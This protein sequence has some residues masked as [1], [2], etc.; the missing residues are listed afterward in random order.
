M[1]SLSRVLIA[2]VL[3]GL[4]VWLLDAAAD[5]WFF[6]RGETFLDL[7]VVSPPP[8]EIY[9]R[10]LI[11]V[12]FTC[13]GVFTTRLLRR[14]YTVSQNLKRV[15]RDKEILLREVHHRVK[16]N[17]SVILGLITLEIDAVSSESRVLEDL[18]ARVNS[19]ALIHNYLYRGEHLEAV[20][21][22]R[23]ISELTDEIL[24]VYVSDKLTIAVKKTLDEVNVSLDTAVPCGLV[25]CELIQNACKHAFVGRDGG[26]ISVSL[27]RVNRG[28]A[29]EVSDDG[30]GAEARDSENEGDPPIGFTLVKALAEQVN[31]RLETYVG[32]GVSV[33][34]TVPIGKTR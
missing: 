21:L 10:I 3:M 5:Y 30:R 14:E 7:L 22:D 6:Y 20:A 15:V 11:L 1:K 18:Y 16:N 13:F 28:F 31:A 12:F 9:I 8:H 2:S 24:G 19:I 26:T 27:R 4:S 29:I 32:R 23:Y 25:L 17:L 33:V 34:L